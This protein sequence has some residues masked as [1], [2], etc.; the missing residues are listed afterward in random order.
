[1][2]WHD[3]TIIDALYTAELSLKPASFSHPVMQSDADTYTVATHPH[4]HKLSIV[5]KQVQTLIIMRA[6][7]YQSMTFL[8]PPPTE[9]P[10]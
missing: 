10:F 9:M 6:G 2:V 1:M 3:R 7:F 5:D 8:F 4:A